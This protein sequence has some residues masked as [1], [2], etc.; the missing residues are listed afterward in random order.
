M[1]S[2]ILDDLLPSILLGRMFSSLG[3]N[4]PIKG[5]RGASQAS[6]QAGHW[7][8]HPGGQMKSQMC[9]GFSQDSDSLTIVVLFSYQ[10]SII[11][12]PL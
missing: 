4:S 12:L 7:C 9:T 5:T 8:L 10:C 1:A 6:T 3:A 11:V 2:S